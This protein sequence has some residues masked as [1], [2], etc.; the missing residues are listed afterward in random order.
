MSAS[1]SVYLSVNTQWRLSN[2]LVCQALAKYYWE[3][4]AW[5]KQTY[6]RY[7]DCRLCSRNIV[8]KWTRVYSAIVDKWTRVYSAIV[9]QWTGVYSTIVEKWMR[10]YSTIVE[11]GMRYST[12]VEKWMRI[13]SIIVEKWTRVYSTPLLSNESGYIVSSLRNEWGYIV[14]SLNN[15]C[16][17]TEHSRTSS[18][19]NA[20]YHGTKRDLAYIW[21]ISCLWIPHT[22]CKIWTF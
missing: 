10:V 15:E 17:Y 12:I 2:I 3:L 14:P 20:N 5:N 22:L 11:K 6:P 21:Y 16:E 9:E 8:D 1:A 19:K 13:Y 18:L 7:V 4:F